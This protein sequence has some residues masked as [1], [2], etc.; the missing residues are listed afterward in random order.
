MT[1]QPLFIRIGMNPYIRLRF[2]REA[3]QA[4]IPAPAIKE[5]DHDSENSQSW[6]KG[7]HL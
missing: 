5:T 4:V 6:R 1:L 3:E 7:C 2:L